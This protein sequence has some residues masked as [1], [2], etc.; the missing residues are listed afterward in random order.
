M[1]RTSAL[2]GVAGAKMS[3]SHA[4]ESP[5]TT[6]GVVF[7]DTSPGGIEW[8]DAAREHGWDETQML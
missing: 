2:A 7:M 5:S 6:K 4:L 1:D 3:L 8:M